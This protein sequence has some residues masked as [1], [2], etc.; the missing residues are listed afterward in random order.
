MYNPNLLIVWIP[1]LAVDPNLWVEEENL[2]LLSGSQLLDLPC[3]PCHRAQLNT[4][5]R[6][7]AILHAVVAFLSMRIF[8]KDVVLTDPI[9]IVKGQII[10]RHINWDHGLLLSSYSKL[11]RGK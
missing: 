7:N 3:V 6:K 1:V 10:F 5:T 2:G 4:S 11:C 9:P 8:A